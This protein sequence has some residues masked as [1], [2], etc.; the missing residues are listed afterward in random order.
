MN[1]ADLFDAMGLGPVWELRKTATHAASA[2]PPTVASQGE[3]AA[4]SF[5][6]PVHRAASQSIDEVQAQVK[7]CQACALHRTRTQTVFAAGQFGAP[8]MVVGEAPGADEDQAGEPFVGRAGQLLD[9]MLKAIGHSRDSNTYIANVL[10]CR[11]PGNRNPEADEIAHCANFLRAQIELGQP[12]ALFLVGKFAIQ[13]LLQSSATVGELRGRVHAVDVQGVSIPVVVGYH[14]AYLLRRPAE[15][16]K[17]WDD[18]LLLQATL[19]ATI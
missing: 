5:M 7:A 10:K 12:K 18:L 13:T 17:A 8:L 1:K 6:Q 15:K 4:D 3:I 16:A 19:R 9:R 14:P 11:P 2:T